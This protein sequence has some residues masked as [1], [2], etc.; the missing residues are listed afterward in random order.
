VT[1][2]LD[3]SLTGQTAYERPNLIL[4]SPYSPNR[5]LANYLNPAA[6][7]QPDLGTY[8]NLGNYAILGPGAVTLN[9]GLTRTVR[10]RERYSMQFRVEAFNLPNH[11]NPGSPTGVSGAAGVVTP[12]VALNNPL[13]GRILS[14]DDPRILQ[15]A[16]KFV[17]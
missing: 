12:V 17:F 16:L 13:F 9:M 8:G 6:F 11:L 5:T 7:K 4:A 10:F 2:G 3:Q 15:G 14:A 1:T